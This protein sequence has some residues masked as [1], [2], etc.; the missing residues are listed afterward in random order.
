MVAAPHEKHQN[1]VNKWPP[2]HTGVK[3]GPKQLNMQN[4]SIF[5]DSIVNL[6]K[7]NKKPYHRT[8]HLKNDSDSDKTDSSH[9]SGKNVITWAWPTSTTII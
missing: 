6:T 3:L 5:L 4:N 9:E 8:F 1:D 2:S 7:I